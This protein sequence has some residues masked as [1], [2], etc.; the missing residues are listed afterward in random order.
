MYGIP[1]MRAG[2]RVTIKPIS[3]RRANGR[4]IYQ[5]AACAPGIFIEPKK[6][7]PQQ[8]DKHHWVLNL[9]EPRRVGT[10]INPTKALFSQPSK[11]IA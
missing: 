11:E 5:V 7:W 3:R 8:Y 10:F 2:F 9:Q 1:Y 4:R 6:I